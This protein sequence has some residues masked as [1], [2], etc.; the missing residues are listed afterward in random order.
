MTAKDVN[1]ISHKARFVKRMAIFLWLFLFW[2]QFDIYIN[3]LP[4][5]DA[6]S[7][8]EFFKQTYLELLIG[9]FLSACVA[10]LAQSTIKLA[11]FLRILYEKS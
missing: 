8:L 9:T 7:P 6:I 3:K 11:D 10:L 2:Y 5:G 4:F 1:S